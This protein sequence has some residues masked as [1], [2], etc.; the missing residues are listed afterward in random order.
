MATTKQTTKE[1]SSNGK[2]GNALGN[3]YNEGIQEIVK[4][5][6]DDNYAKKVDNGP[7]K[8][9]RGKDTWQ[10]HSQLSAVSRLNQNLGAHVGS[11][12]SHL[13]DLD[14]HLDAAT[15]LLSKL[16]NQTHKETNAT[17]A[18]NLETVGS[19]VT[20]ARKALLDSV[21]ATDKGLTSTVKDAQKSL[22]AQLKESTS[23][24]DKSLA[25]VHE[26]LT[27]QVTETTT[28]LS[29]HLEK[30]HTGV[31]ERLETVH[32]SMKSA[33]QEL[34]RATAGSEENI[35]AQTDSFSKA[36]E[37]LLNDVR[38]DLDAKISEFRDDATRLID[39]RFNQSDVSF[40]AVRADQEV[41]KAL[42]TDII[43]DRLGRAEPR[44]R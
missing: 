44:V 16:T 22:Q 19:W 12:E 4:L 7:L 5:A 13:N 2:T 26:T 25:E 42:L 14:G 27:T 15:E 10:V 11:L 29:D 23:S 1:E 30:V 39:K 33:F 9:A 17:L 28:E 18:S 20:A 21:S 34:A 41:I 37:T 6:E 3:L 35:R 8:E 38:G 32:K 43:K 40:A 36:V 31:N 24:L